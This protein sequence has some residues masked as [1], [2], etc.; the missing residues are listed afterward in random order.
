MTNFE[1]FKQELAKS[2]QTVYAVAHW[3]TG[4][5]YAVTLPPHSVAERPEDW[6]QHADSGDLHL[7]L[8]LE[9]KRRQI[10]FTCQKDF[11][12]PDIMVS[13]KAVYDR[14]D[15]KPSTHYMVNKAGTHMAVIRQTS[16]QYWEVRTVRDK[17][18]HSKEVYHCPIERVSFQGL[19][20]AL[21]TPSNTPPT[22]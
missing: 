21:P 16:S 9:V 3:L 2:H 17:R 20:G 1:H 10:D 18:G 19:P 6:E 8:R 13:A 15:P 12:F 22:A 14:A 11:P 4:R 5:G 7:H